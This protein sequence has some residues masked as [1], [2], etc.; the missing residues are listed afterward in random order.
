MKR[1]IKASDMDYIPEITFD[2]ADDILSALHYALDVK[3][4]KRYKSLQ[5]DIDDVTCEDNRVK[6]KISLYNNGKIIVESWFDFA[7]YDE[8]FD[9]DDY[10]SHINR[11][12]YEFV[13][14]LK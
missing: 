7:A 2:E 6:A 14:Y 1:Y 9:K 3:Y 4:S 10:D 11:T 12:I 5:I 8:Y 13:K